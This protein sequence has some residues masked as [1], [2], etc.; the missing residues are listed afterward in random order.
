MFCRTLEYRGHALVLHRISVGDERKQTIRIDDVSH[1]YR[2]TLLF[3]TSLRSFRISPD[4]TLTIPL[5]ARNGLLT[6]STKTLPSSI[7]HSLE[8]EMFNFSRVRISRG[9]FT[10]NLEVILDFILFFLRI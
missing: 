7:S 10:W 5:Y 8:S 9:M 2:S 6:G 3:L 1:R 4:P